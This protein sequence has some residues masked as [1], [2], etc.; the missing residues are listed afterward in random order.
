VTS[1][2][3]VGVFLVAFAASWH[4]RQREYSSAHLPPLGAVLLRDLAVAKSLSSPKMH[5]ALGAVTRLAALIPPSG[6]SHNHSVASAA[7]CTELA[8]ELP[9]IYNMVVTTKGNPPDLA[10]VAFLSAF[11]MHSGQEHL[12]KVVHKE[13]STPSSLPTLTTRLVHLCASMVDPL[14]LVNASST[15]CCLVHGLPGLARGILHSLLGNV[16]TAENPEKACNVAKA[17]HICLRSPHAP[18]NGPVATGVPPRSLHLDLAISACSR[19]LVSS[20][21]SY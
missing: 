16:T 5:A 11:V 3:I 13:P 6:R 10:A 1:H 20:A 15:L 18:P 17:L 21:C 2:K 14:V 19:A 4:T 8:A 12:A 9:N 7:L